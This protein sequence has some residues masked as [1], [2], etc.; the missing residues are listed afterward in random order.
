MILRFVASGSQTGMIGVAAGTR[1]TRLSS[2]LCA[3]LSCGALSAQSAMNTPPAA[4]VHIS[5]TIRQC[6][7]PS[8][9]GPFRVRFEG[10]PL[11]PK[12]VEANDGGV[13]ETDL[14]F[15]VWT[16]TLGTDPHDDT[17]DLARPRHFQATA[18]GRLAFDI[19]L[20]PPVMCDVRGTPE[21]RAKLCWAEE[22]FQ[23][24]SADG[25]P[26]EVDLFNLHQYWIPCPAAQPNSHHRE[27]A[28]YNLLSI[29]ADNVAYHPSEKILEASGDVL[30]RDEAGEHKSD[31]VRLSLQEGRVSV[32]PRDR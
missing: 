22:F 25:V 31:S 1:M 5:G 6:G 2:C 8:H 30:M 24:P 12:I 21:G 13:Y 14:P 32:L 4:Q 11:R 17:K 26:Y 3:L 9:S 16:M 19:Y 7:K 23:V 28:T 10:P 20:R 27:F 18:S 15:G 29:E